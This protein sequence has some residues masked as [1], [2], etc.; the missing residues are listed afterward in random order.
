M[1]SD[2]HTDFVYITLRQPKCQEKNLCHHQRNPTITILRVRL[3]IGK[4]SLRA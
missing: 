2:V 4:T 1:S 3:V